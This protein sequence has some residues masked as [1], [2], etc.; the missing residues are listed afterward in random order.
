M[1]DTGFNGGRL[2]R[3]IYSSLYCLSTFSTTS[4]S[5]DIWH[6]C[7]SHPGSEFLA[8]LIR[9][10]F[11]LPNKKWSIMVLI[12]LVNTSGQFSYCPSIPPTSH[13][14]SSSSS[15]LHMHNPSSILNPSSAST[16]ECPKSLSLSSR[17]PPVRSSPTPTISSKTDTMN[18]R[19][20]SDAAYPSHLPLLLWTHMARSPQDHVVATDATQDQ[21]SHLP[22]T[23]STASF[24][25]SQYLFHGH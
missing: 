18:A 7:H 23:I 14:P 6:L 19:S 9:H 22:S 17:M 2:W 8:Y 11:L 20:I 16:S 24:C 3:V 13:E 1:C 10:G 15:P 12:I 25:S 4:V 5:S 21:V